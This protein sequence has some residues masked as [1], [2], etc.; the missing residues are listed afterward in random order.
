MIQVPGHI[1]SIQSY[2]PGKTIEE[3]VSENNWKEYAVLWNNENTL[4]VSP[5]AIKAVQEAL[6]GSNYYPD[7]RARELCGK[8]AAKVGRSP[9]EI[10]LSNG[11]EGL[12]MSIIRAFCS[13][14]DEFLTSQG[15]FVIIYNWAKVNNVFCRT[16]PLSEGYGFDLESILKAINRQTKMIYLSNINNPTG[17]MISK[18]DLIAFL[19]K[20][21]ENILVIVDEAYFEFSQDLSDDFPDCTT[22]GFP[23][24]LSLRTFSK[25]YGIAGVRLG[26]AIASR[27]IIDT[28]YKARLTFEPGNLA[29]ASGMGAIQDDNFLNKTLKNNR[30]ALSYY[31]HEFDKLGINYIPSFGNF[32]MTALDS[33]SEAKRIFEELLKRG[34]FVRHLGGPLSHCIRISMGRPEENELCIRMLKEVI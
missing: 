11:S 34:V 23:N 33:E 8:I 26:Y 7:P 19:E 5:K 21:P 9:E 30:E 25:V 14:D 27:E 6:D 28:L 18:V 22:L 31:Y 15:T 2:Q 13:G 24:V 3:L 12:L 1:K 29:Q 16:V 4:G 20:V 17:T 32:V 10:I